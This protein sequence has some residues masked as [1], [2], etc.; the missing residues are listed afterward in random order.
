[1]SSL[2]RSDLLTPSGPASSRLPWEARRSRAGCRRAGRPRRGRPDAEAVVHPP[3]DGGRAVADSTRSTSSPITPTA[4]RSAPIPTAAPGVRIG[5]HLPRLARQM[6]RLAV[7]RSMQTRKATMAGRP[8]I[9]R[10]GYTPQGSIRFPTLGALVSQRTA[11]TRQPTCPASSASCRR[12]RSRSA[13]VAAGFLGPH[14][15][16]LVVDGRGGA[17][18]VDD[19][20]QRTDRPLAA[21]TRSAPRNGDAVPDSRPGPG[22][23]SH[24]HR[25]RSRRSASAPA[26]AARLRSRPQEPAS[27][28]RSLRPQQRSARD[29]CWPAGWSSAACRSSR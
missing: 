5:E 26:A 11:P 21:A 22:T 13:S 15:A 12:G 10:T 6:K 14:H 24:V 3:V 19:F 18:H 16:P 20:S 9:S 4:G 1:M 28:A 8:P 25:I 23:A 29:V 27:R 2:R 17:L 7:I